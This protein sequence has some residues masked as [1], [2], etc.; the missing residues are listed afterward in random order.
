M[1]RLACRGVRD[2]TET[3]KWPVPAAY[4][5]VQ[6]DGGARRDVRAQTQRSFCIQRDGRSGGPAGSHPAALGTSFAAGAF[7]SP[8]PW[9]PA[10]PDGCAS[11]AGSAPLPP[12]PWHHSCLWLLTAPSAARLAHLHPSAPWLSAGRPC[13][14]S[15]HP[16]L[17][18]PAA[19]ARGLCVLLA[20]VSI[21]A[22]TVSPGLVPVSV[23]PS[24]GV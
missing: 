13:A 8:Q 22:L 11:P 1:T 6:V 9:P 24:S 10:V 5:H 12:R 7:L 23:I 14:L 19:W 4:S 20:P 16:P 21:L 18:R 17:G 15:L 2:E 3:G